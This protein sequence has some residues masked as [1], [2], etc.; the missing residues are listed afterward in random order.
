MQIDQYKNEPIYE[1]I[2]QQYVAYIS[3]GIL[4]E[5]EKL[6][7]VRQLSTKL[8]INPNT[9]VKAYRMLEEHGFIYSMP[10]K[11]SFVSKVQDVQ[12]LKMNEEI[13]DILKHL[14]IKCN[15]ANVTYQEICNR[16]KAV[17]E[18]KE[19]DTDKRII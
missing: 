8:H 16:L 11:G 4:Q 6:P 17:W 1:Q 14:V 7:S 19:Y 12:L 10:G 13:N 15:Y 18:E 2:Y 3:K 9:V 5:N